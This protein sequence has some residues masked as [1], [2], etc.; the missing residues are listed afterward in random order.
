MDNIT[1]SLIGAVAARCALS[2][3]PSLRTPNLALATMLTS[4]AANNIADL[5]FLIAPF[6]GNLKLGALLHHRG[7]THTFFFAPVTALLAMGLSFLLLAIFRK[8]L[9]ADRAILK[10]LFLVGLLGACLHF[11]ADSWNFSKVDFAKSRKDWLLADKAS[12]DK[13]L[14]V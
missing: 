11:L 3:K 6:S 1:H 13:A 5:D 2:S 8:K 12:A 9:K 4:I 10:F 14:K 7:I